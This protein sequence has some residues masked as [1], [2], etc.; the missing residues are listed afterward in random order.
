MP[1]P[2]LSFSS[3]SSYTDSTGKQRKRFNKF[4]LFAPSLESAGA[5][6]DGGIMT[7]VKRPFVKSYKT[8][9]QAFLEPGQEPFSDGAKFGRSYQLHLALQAVY[10]FEEKNGHLPKP[11]DDKDTAAVVAIANRIHE[12]AKLINESCG[13][14]VVHTVEAV[15]EDIIAKVA[16]HAAVNLQP[17]CVFFGGVVAQEIVKVAGKYT[18]NDQW[19]HLDWFEVLPNT[20]PTDTQPLKSRYD[21]SI[22][23]FGKAIQDKIMAASTFVVGCGALGCELLKNY[24]LLGVACG[25]GTLHTTDNDNVEISNLNRQFL[26][27]PQHVKKSK[28]VS[29]GN[30]VKTMNPDFNV[31]A[32]NKLVWQKSEDF[33][34]DAFWGSLTFITNALDNVKARLYVDARCV[35]FYKALLESGTL[36]TKCHSQVVV[37]GLTQSYADGPKV[38]RNTEGTLSTCTHHSLPRP[39]LLLSPGCR[40]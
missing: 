37:P 23:I 24:A 2:A 4:A 31:K 30:V 20:R 14:R 5:D 3:T 21:D 16:R 1:S 36:G 12:A 13:G 9:S 27:R 6:M 19:L 32:Y 26:F 34:N 17:V 39:L 22:A 18:P 33:F 10:S 28:S 15:D 35:F 40:R 25:G 38:M 29:A 8:L 11:N 7:Q